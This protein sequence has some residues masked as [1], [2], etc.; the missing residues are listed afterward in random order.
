MGEAMLQ[1]ARR[2]QLQS[3]RSNQLQSA[4]LDQLQSSAD[5]VSAQQHGTSAGHLSEGE[6]IGE[7]SDADGTYQLG[8]EGNKHDGSDVL[9]EEE[10][11][12]GK[13]VKLPSSKL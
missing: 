12:R 7:G 8:V 11:G 13:Q 4:S 5:Q 9:S 6:M 1:S 3:A 10:L 2:D